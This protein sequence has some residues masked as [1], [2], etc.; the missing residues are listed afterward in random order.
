MHKLLV[1]FPGRPVA[2]T[3]DFH[4]RGHEFSPWSA[5]GDP[6]NCVARPKNKKLMSMQSM[7]VAVCTPV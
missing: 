4:F 7:T 3:P 6:I 1:E 2:R 5:N